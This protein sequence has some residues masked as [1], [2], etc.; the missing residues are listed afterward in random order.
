MR[1][2]KFAPLHTA[3]VRFFAGAEEVL[4]FAAV[5]LSSWRCSAAAADIAAAA[6][7]LF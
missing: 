5:L 3:S 4:A 6:S 7:A 2:A 1:S